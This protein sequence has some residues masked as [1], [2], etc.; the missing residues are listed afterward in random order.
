MFGVFGFSDFRISS[1]SSAFGPTIAC[2][3]PY[4][5]AVFPNAVARV[6]NLHHAVVETVWAK[7]FGYRNSLL[8]PAA[9]RP[10]W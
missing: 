2:I 8:R 7:S 5:R 3:V 4:A 6:Y 9:N 10:K 1:C